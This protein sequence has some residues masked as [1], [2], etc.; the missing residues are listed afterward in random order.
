MKTKT[1]IYIAA[2]LSVLSACTSIEVEEQDT[3]IS[4][5][6]SEQDVNVFI[7]DKVKYNIVPTP[8][9]AQATTDS[10][11]KAIQDAK[12]LGYE[13]IRLEEGEYWICS[14]NN[15]RWGRPKE[16]IFIPSNTEFDLNNSVLRLRPNDN[17][18]YGIIQLHAVENVTIK[19]GHLIGD[20]YEHTYTPHPDG[21]HATHEYGFGV[22][23]LA[24]DNITIEDMTIEQMT[25]D[26]IIAI[27][28][29]QALNPD[30]SNRYCTNLVIQNNKLFDCRRQGISICHAVDVYIYNNEIYHIGRYR[31]AEDREPVDGTDPGSGI[32][33]EPGPYEQYGS[34]AENVRIHENYIHHC[35]QGISF[36]TG[37]DNEAVGNL[38]ED[39]RW[40]GIGASASLRIRIYNNTFNRSYIHINHLATD[41]CAP[42]T[43]EYRNILNG[44]AH[45][46]NGATITGYFPCPK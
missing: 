45:I 22:H 20:R 41:V 11:N 33:V 9:N 2:I 14:D 44:N 23:I 13:K 39:T 31:S 40:E 15:I 34:I 27:G 43:G 29:A 28:S 24:S 46:Y 35:V 6:K 21:S 1:I 42:E 17:I 7:I 25:G 30:G 5:E 16:G 4:T 26:A 37:N 19:N 12:L 38:V 32:D 8:T 10:I 18:V 36:H 3:D